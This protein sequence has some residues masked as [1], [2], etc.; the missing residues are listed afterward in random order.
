M[1]HLLNDFFF[2]CLRTHTHVHTNIKKTVFSVLTSA[3][4]GHC[5]PSLC[6]LSVSHLSSFPSSCFS[7]PPPVS[8]HLADNQENMIDDQN[9]TAG[10]FHLQT[11]YSPDGTVFIMFQVWANPALPLAAFNTAPVRSLSLTE[12]NSNEGLTFLER[13]YSILLVVFHAQYLKWNNLIMR[14]DGVKLC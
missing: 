2:F 14:A 7:S 11:K 10:S 9:V 3:L 5:V 4:S 1:K 12:Q 13:M 6:L 8:G